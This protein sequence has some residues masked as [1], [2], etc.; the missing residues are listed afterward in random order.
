MIRFLV[1][2]GMIAAAVAAPGNVYGN[3]TP[4][5]IQ[6]G[7][8]V[9]GTAQTGATASSDGQASAAPVVRTTT[10][11]VE[12]GVVA[13]DR[14]GHVVTD[15]SQSDFEIYDNGRLQQIKYF[16][17]GAPGATA[18]SAPASASA[19]TA[20]KNS[21]ISSANAQ[22]SQRG[23]D[24][25]T[26]ILLIDSNN[27][28]WRDLNYARQQMLEFL[29]KLPQAD[30]VGLYILRSDRIEIL[31]E[32]VHDHA[33]VAA[34]LEKWMPNALEL[35]HAQEAD[36]TNRQQYRQRTQPQRPG[37]CEW[38]RPHRAGVVRAPRERNAGYGGCSFRQAA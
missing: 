37:E 19:V 4:D 22:D 29:K 1:S 24:A 23:S 3:K 5:T 6:P 25:G 20:G 32:P 36:R 31:S 8:E 10:R 2:C 7:Q 16:G 38:Q 15:L 11:L 13:Y 30:S 17:G 28:A 9:S 35:A 14:H 27:L 21:E 26:T 34:I 18:S 33:E 12:L